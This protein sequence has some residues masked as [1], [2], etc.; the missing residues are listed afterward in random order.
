MMPEGTEMSLYVTAGS[1]HP[2]VKP[3]T[4][5]QKLI[6]AIPI[7]A[8]DN[9]TGMFFDAL[10]EASERVHKDKTPGYPMIVMIGSDQGAMRTLDRD[11]QKLQMN[12]FT[13]GIRTH[14]LLDVVPGGAAGGGQVDLGLN[15]TKFSGGRY[16]NF[17]TV[18]RLATLL[19]EIGKSV[20][21][22]IRLQSHQYRVTYELCKPN[23]KGGVSIGAEVRKEGTV[24]LSLRGVQ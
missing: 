21:E 24:K 5:K 11:F 4:D 3:T 22:S 6:D 8:P 16:E 15:I 7:I 19:P 12:V 20:A 23:D 18:T 2:I 14:V 1:P 17:N 9:S 13:H 10:L